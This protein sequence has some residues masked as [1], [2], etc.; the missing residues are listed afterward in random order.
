MKRPSMEDEYVAVAAYLTDE[1]LGYDHWRAAQFC[2]PGHVER[3][4]AILVLCESSTEQETI[5][6]ELKK[7]QRP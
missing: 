7:R 3:R 2:P 5:L 4:P 1:V 6:A